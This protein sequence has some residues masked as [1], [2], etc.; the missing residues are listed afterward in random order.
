MKLQQ[1]DLQRILANRPADLRGILVYGP[2]AG[3]VSET[4]E[5]L[6]RSVVEDPSDPF[7][8]VILSGDTLRQD[9]TAL[10]DAATAMSLTGG[11]P[12]GLGSR[13][14]RRPGSAVPGS[15]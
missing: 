15:R 14:D 6:A 13:R 1:R 8:S 7:R 12:A 2:D 9:P 10:I 11:Q 5:V 4:A 3:H